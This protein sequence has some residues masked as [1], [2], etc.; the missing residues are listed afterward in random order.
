[1][2]S[3]VDPP[4]EATIPTRPRSIGAFEVGRVLPAPARR[5]VGPFAFLD[6]M[7]PAT[8]PPGGGMDVRPH[9]HIHLATVTYLFEGEVHHRDSVGSSQVI[10]PGAINWMI[11]G[12]GIV[13]S[14]RSPAEARER[15]A[16]VHGLQ[17]WVALPTSHEDVAPSFSHHPAETIPGW[18]EGGARV[19]VLAGEAR[20][21]RSP[22]PTASPLSYL[23]LELE[24]GARFEVPA[25]HEERA[26]YVVAGELRCGDRAIPERTM[27]VLR[28]RASYTLEARSRARAVVLG[29]APLDGPRWI[30]WN[31]VSSSRERIEHAARE[32]REGRFPKVPGD[33]LESIPL[34]EEPRFPREPR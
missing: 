26:I 21:V 8:L 7:G 16:R 23:E 22:V 19:R 25:E 24:V 33:E 31:F 14:E 4:F 28:P 3:P 17:L 18:R 9:P 10:R 12:R 27:V 34:T 15:G 30:W 13:H 1:M 20:G 11:A 29:G 2:E 6:H 5:M 32:W